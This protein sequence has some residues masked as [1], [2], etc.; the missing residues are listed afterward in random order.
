MK[1]FIIRW[2][3]RLLIFVVMTLGIIESINTKSILYTMVFVA[4]LFIGAITCGWICPAGLLQDVLFKCGNG[5]NKKIPDISLKI[6][7][8]IRWLRYIFAGTLVTGVFVLPAT[9]QHGIGN[10][11]KLQFAGAYIS[12]A[13]AI[14]SIFI[15][16]FFCRYC[17]PYGAIA[18]IKS[19]IRPLTIKKNKSLCINCKKCD[20]VCPMKIEMSKV[21]SSCSPNCINCFKCMENCPKKALYIGIREYK[22]K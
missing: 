12:I 2:G 19:L 17:C 10:L 18:G 1:N 6:H 4:P 22:N 8:K 7:K 16:R 11:T 9:I 3:I 21:I 20:N 5:L 13:F 15:N 14:I